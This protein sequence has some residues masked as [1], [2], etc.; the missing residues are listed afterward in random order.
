MKNSFFVVLSVAFAASFCK[1]ETL[2]AV[3][4]AE[5]CCQQEDGIWC[6]VQ[7]GETCREKCASCMGTPTLVYCTDF[8]CNPTYIWEA[9]GI[10]YEVLRGYCEDGNMC[11]QLTFLYRC[12]AGYYGSP[13][14]SLSGCTECPS[15]GTSVAGSNTSKTDCY[16]PA[17]TQL[18]DSSGTFTYTTN[19]YYSN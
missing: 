3:E 6:V 8:G 1:I 7:P 5:R 10:G 17:N 15:P 14:S 11:S 16:I 19:C 18:T 13:T 4:V 9:S 2:I 12:A